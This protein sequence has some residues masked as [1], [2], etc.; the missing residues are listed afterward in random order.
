ME[1]QENNIPL[2]IKA[3]NSIISIVSILREGDDKAKSLIADIYKAMAM[4]G[5]TPNIHTFNAALNVAS[6]F[7]NKRIILNFTLNIFADIAKFKLKPTL[8]TYYYVL[9]ILN[10]FG[11]Y[12]IFLFRKTLLRIYR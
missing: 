8:T 1:C 6:M 12:I 5:V 2:S 10:K 3:Y 11:N 7:K 9:R 4:N